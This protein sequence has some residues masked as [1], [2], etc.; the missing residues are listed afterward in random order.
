MVH[1]L[2]KIRRLLKPNGILIDIRPPPEPSAIDVRIGDRM[3]A[4][5]WLNETDDYGDYEAADTA[6]AKVVDGGLFVVERRGEFELKT[7]ADTL[8]ELRDYVAEGWENASI[9]DVTTAR[10]EEWMSTAERDK[11]IL[12]R[13]R[14]RIARLRPV[15]S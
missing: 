5:G 6:L 4:A 12:L 15:Q 13:E 1:A 14:V 8:A 3:H 9:D 7:Y 11:E 10:I 2:E